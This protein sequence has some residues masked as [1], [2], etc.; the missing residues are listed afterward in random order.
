MKSKKKMPLVIFIFIIV[1]G[2]ASIGCYYFNARETKGLNEKIKLSEK[3]ENDIIENKVVE[4]NNDESEL[5][6]NTNIYVEESNKEDKDG[7]SS[8]KQNT[9]TNETN[10]NISNNKTEENKTVVENKTDVNTEN[11]VETEVEE[12]DDSQTEDNVVKEE[13]NNNIETEKSDNKVVIEVP[14]EESREN[15]S[16][17]ENDEEYINLKS[18]LEFETKAECNAAEDIIGP[19]YAEQGVLKNTACESFAY[20][21]TIIGY[22]LQ[23]FFKDGTWIYN[24]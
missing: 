20:K 9:I 11:K 2:I 19:I 3:K 1:L 13:T 21:G 6:S 10:K 8:V 5:N 14:D 4:S 12:N 16:T 7:E 24:N 15:V 23:I 22:R 17:F 18:T